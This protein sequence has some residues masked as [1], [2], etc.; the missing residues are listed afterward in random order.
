M[1]VASALIF[2]L[3][4]V[5]QGGVGGLLVL[6]QWILLALTGAIYLWANRDVPLRQRP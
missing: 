4:A 2:L 3:V 5:W 6:P 1:W